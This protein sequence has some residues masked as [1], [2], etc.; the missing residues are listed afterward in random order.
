MQLLDGRRRWLK[1]VEV[2]PLRFR[3]QKGDPRKAL[4]AEVDGLTAL[5]A[6]GLPVAPVIA[7]GPGCLGAADL[8]PSQN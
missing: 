5:A 2:L 6:R 8:G 3:L 1:R 4:A 7:A